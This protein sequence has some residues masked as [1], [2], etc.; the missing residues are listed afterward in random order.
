MDDIFDKYM[1]DG[2]FGVYPGY[3]EYVYLC[4]GKI[5]NFD[6][7][8]YHYQS[9]LLPKTRWPKKYWGVN[10]PRLLEIKKKYDPHNVYSNPQSVG[11]DENTL[12]LKS[13][14]VVDGMKPVLNIEP[15]VANH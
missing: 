6:G 12:P 15:P 11:A 8:Y 3:V 9:P 13:A 2:D 10:Y 14:F 4:P 5:Q 7:L 1:P